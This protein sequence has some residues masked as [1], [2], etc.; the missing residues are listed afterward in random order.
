MHVFF[1]GRGIHAGILQQLHTPNEF[2]NL[3]CLHIQFM[4]ISTDR[5]KFMKKNILIDFAYLTIQA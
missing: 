5:S 4:Y 2:E 1:Q 3:F